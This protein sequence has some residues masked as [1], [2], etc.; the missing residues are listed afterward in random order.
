MCAKERERGKERG[1]ERDVGK[2]S[3]Q[4]ILVFV[5]AKKKNRKKF[6]ELRKR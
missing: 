3:F 2:E 4:K 5:S 6:S 1:R